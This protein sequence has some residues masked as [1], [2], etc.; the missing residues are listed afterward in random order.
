MASL[1]RLSGDDILQVGGELLVLA[2]YYILF[3]LCI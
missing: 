2:L 3:E 1:Y